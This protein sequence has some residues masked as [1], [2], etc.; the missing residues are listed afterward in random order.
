MINYHAK[1]NAF[2][3]KRSIFTPICHNSNSDKNV[4]SVYQNL[5]FGVD[6]YKQIKF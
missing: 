6:N 5:S 2:I 4:I 1:N 3:I